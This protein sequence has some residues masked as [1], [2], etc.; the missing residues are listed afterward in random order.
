M[1]F[2]WYSFVLGF[3]FCILLQLR[4]I[5]A[6]IINRTKPTKELY[7]WH[8]DFVAL[9]SST[10]KRCCILWIWAKW[11]HTKGWREQKKEK[12]NVINESLTYNWYCCCNTWSNLLNLNYCL[13]K[14]ITN[15]VWQRRTEKND[16]TN[17]NRFYVE[18]IVDFYS[19]NTFAHMCQ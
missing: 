3:F 15:C 19:S 2:C 7:F 11:I 18:N 4:H 1:D 8:I 16:F 9:C 14:L 17:S 5:A 10:C 13:L 12:T 6:I